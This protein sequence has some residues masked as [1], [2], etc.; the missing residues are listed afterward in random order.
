MQLQP[1]E[2]DAV[3]AADWAE[4]QALHSSGVSRQD[5]A[6]AADL[7]GVLNEDDYQEAHGL[8]NESSSFFVSD[9]LNEVN[10]R[11]RILSTRY[12]FELNE[13]VLSF[14][15]GRRWTPYT[16]CLV[17]S[18]RDGWQPADPSPRMFEHLTGAALGSFLQ[19]SWARFGDPRDTLPDPVDEALDTLSAKTGDPRQTPPTGIVV[20]PRDQDFG[21]DIAAWKGFSDERRGSVQVYAQCATTPEWRSKLG[22]PDLAPAGTWD[23]LISWLLPPLKAMAVPFVLPADEDQW[24][25]DSRAVLLLDRLRIAS[26]LRQLPP[27]PPGLPS[28]AAWA[29]QWSARAAAA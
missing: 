7:A 14:R 6:S 5:V 18:D 29:R 27:L 13:G 24:R 15:G 2:K 4:L 25:R 12:P 19:G 21:L 22:E 10:R 28:W 23:N 26:L 16:F 20:G 1:K 17:V 11:A 3:K 8:A 9:Y